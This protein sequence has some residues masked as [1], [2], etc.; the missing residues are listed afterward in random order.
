MPVERL[1][2][3][4][5]L[6]TRDE[7]CDA[8][9]RAADEEEEP[10]DA[11]AGPSSAWET[12]G[13]VAPQVVA[14]PTPLE[15]DMA[16]TRAD[17]GRRLLSGRGTADER[18][19]RGVRETERSWEPGIW[20]KKGVCG[21]RWVIPEMWGIVQAYVLVARPRGR[22]WNQIPDKRRFLTRVSAR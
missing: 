22:V 21:W 3:T 9:A 8:R 6:E 5:V 4:R 11:I 2:P 1:D 18:S 15:V 10:D 16:M 12:T 13:L 19:E 7:P 17:V 14:L 20:R